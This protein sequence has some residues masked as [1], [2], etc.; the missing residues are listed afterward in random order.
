MDVAVFRKLFVNR[1]DTY[2]EQIKK[3]RGYKR[4]ASKLTD[5]VIKDHLNG[6]TTIGLYQLFNGTI[7]WACI[8][9]DIVKDVWSKDDFKYEDWVDQVNLQAIE[10][11]QK[12][13]DAGMTSYLEE[14]GN[15]GAHVWIFF[16]EPKP[17]EPNKPGG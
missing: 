1:D 17:A 6:Q 15:K 13:K 10:W 2:A 7:K 14:S 8:D 4:V 12:L 5:S 3:E 9:I 11:K 16:E